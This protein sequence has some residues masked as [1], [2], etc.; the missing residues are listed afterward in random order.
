[1]KMAGPPN[2]PKGITGSPNEP[3]LAAMSK[4]IST[5]TGTVSFGTPNQRATRRPLTITKPQQEI[6]PFIESG[7]QDHSITKHLQKVYLFK[8]NDGEAPSEEE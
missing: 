3:H 4:S 7:I 6:G 1:M 8:K 2:P 5:C